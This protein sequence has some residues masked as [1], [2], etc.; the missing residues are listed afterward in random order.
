MNSKT[1]W[2]EVLEQVQKEKDKKRR[3]AI[4]FLLIRQKQCL[5]LTDLSKLLNTSEEDLTAF[6]KHGE[7]SE[8]V[9]NR[10]IDW[11]ME[12]LDKRPDC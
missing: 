11:M 4:N 6:E 2:E 12:T 9:F 7:C 10:A 1:D 5:S 8:D 3:A